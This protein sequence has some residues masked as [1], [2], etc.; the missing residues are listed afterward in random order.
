MSSGD[1]SPRRLDLRDAFSEGLSIAASRNGLVF[2]AAFFALEA[3]TVLLYTSGSLYLPLDQPTVVG[4]PSNLPVGTP[5]PSTETIVSEA[6]TSGFTIL[7]SIPLSIV[8]IRTFV[9]GATERIPEDCL[10]HRLGRA[11][12]SSVG[13][14]VL[15]VGGLAVLFGA[16]FGGLFVLD[17]YHDQL[18]PVAIVGTLVLI[19]GVVVVGSSTVVIHVLFVTHEIAVRDRGLREA[20]AGSWAL[21]RGNRVGLLVLAVLLIVVSELVRW[22]GTSSAG[23]ALDP[24]SAT[25]MFVRTVLYSTLWVATTAVIARAYRQLSPDDAVRSGTFG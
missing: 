22:G 13:A 8:A 9:V 25:L 21:A 20:L 16:G 5:L 15:I 14:F 7:L 23:G 6:L 18:G 3:V 2:V 10:S 24:L 19:A 1:G 4:E 12:L 11:T 17:A